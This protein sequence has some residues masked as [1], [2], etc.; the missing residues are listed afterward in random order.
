MCLGVI[1]LNKQ[2]L[3][4]NLESLSQKYEEIDD[5][6]ILDDI[7]QEFLKYLNDNPNDSEAWIQL[8]IFVNEAPL[9]DYISSIKY[10]EQLLS[11]E[12]DNVRALVVLSE[13]EDSNLGHCS[14][15]TY[16]MLSKIRTSNREAMS[17][18]E[19]AMARFHLLNDNK[20]YE[21]H[22]E[23]SVNYYSGH[24]HNNK[25]LAKIYLAQGKLE[26]GCK[27]LKQALRGVTCLYPEIWLYVDKTFSIGAVDEYIA[28]F[29]TGTQT[30]YERFKGIGEAYLSC[31]SLI[32]EKK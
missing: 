10:L 28:E 7:E 19:Y 14:R 30:F 29:I 8:A 20:Q 9:A 4:T 3:V 5:Q 15:K 26:E 12:P 17:I 24:V 25:E 6:K 27:L 1:T 23:R 18:V 13:I 16:D 32:A 21:E 31:K 22:L 11:R 2:E